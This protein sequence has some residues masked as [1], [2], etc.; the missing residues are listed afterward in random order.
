MPA[1]RPTKMTLELVNKLEACFLIGATDTE[2]CIVAGISR[3]TF[4]K[5]CTKNPEFADRK[6]MLKDM[7]SYKARKVVDSALDDN[8]INTAHKVL[9]RKEGSK[10]KQEITGKDGGA[11]ETS[12]TFI[13]NPVGSND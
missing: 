6:D 9:D 12:T 13:F 10:V 7:P 8:D 3:E 4:Y 5:Y 1:G 11:I 2:A